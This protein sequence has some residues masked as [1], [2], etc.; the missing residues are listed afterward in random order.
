V[1]Q[2]QLEPASSDSLSFA[3]PYRVSHA[4]ANGS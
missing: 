1:L 3:P 4:A 2:G